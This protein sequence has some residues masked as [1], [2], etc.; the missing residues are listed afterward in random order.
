M[1]TPRIPVPGRERGPAAAA[2]GPLHLLS[3]ER[4]YG[5]GVAGVSTAA[6]STMA[7]SVTIGS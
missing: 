5:C 2:A 6:P 4:D 3:P 1:S 7:V